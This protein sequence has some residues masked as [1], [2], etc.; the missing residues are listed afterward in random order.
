MIIYEITNIKNNKMY[1]G[2]TSVGIKY[3]KQS[4]KSFSDRGHS[5]PLYDAMKKHG[6]YNFIY[7]I[8][9][10]FDSKEDAYKFKEA[11]ILEFNTMNPEYGYNCTTGSLNKGYKMNK[12]TKEKISKSHT[13]KTMPE[14]WKIWMKNQIK[15]NPNKYKSFKKGYKH[16]EE[17]RANMRLGQKNS[18]YVQT[19]EIK[20]RK[21]VTMKKRW[22]EPETIERMKN[23][24][25]S[26]ITEETRKKMSIAQSGKNNAM[27]GVT[28]KDHWA[29]GK[30]IC[31]EHYNKL[32]IG[33]KKY[34]ENK[35]KEKLEEIK[36]RTEKKCNKC[37][38][39]LSLSMFYKSKSNLDGLDYYCKDCDKKRKSKVK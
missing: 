35:R 39:I 37:N 2:S 36:D 8:A 5:R 12:Q 32:S 3:T 27:Y 26:P 14:S 7:S 30:K 21:S 23:R 13:G 19:E 10:D 29:F 22:T 25:R 33:R 24:V 1:I 6:F 38:Q 11:F 17:A 4:H 15:N 34:Y 31:K 16:T 18:D 9:G 20:K 28:G